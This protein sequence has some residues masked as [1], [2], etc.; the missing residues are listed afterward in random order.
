MVIFHPLDGARMKLDR[1]RA[2]LGAL[3]S[4]L[5]RHLERYPARIETSSPAKSS[6]LQALPLVE[7]DA[8]L[9]PLL[10]SCVIGDCVTNARAALDYVIWELASRFFT[11]P[12]DLAGFDDRRI[13]SFPIE[14]TF[15]GNGF[16]ERLRQLAHRGIH[17]TAID[18]IKASQSEDGAADAL[19]WLHELVNTD[20]HRMPLLTITDIESIEVTLSRPVLH[21]DAAP[22]TMRLP[23]TIV[24][25][26]IPIHSDVQ[27]RSETTFCVTF[28]DASV[29]RAPIENILTPII[30]SV[31]TIVPRFEPFFA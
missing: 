8:E 21:Q 11:P 26:R 27:M 18:T 6:G 16:N 19:R 1:A 22:A 17:G 12:I 31:A 3:R 23:G 10:L 20:K 4:E 2:H 29:P 24:G 30:E 28:K 25:R 7:P 9:P 13:L 15:R 5:G 14:G